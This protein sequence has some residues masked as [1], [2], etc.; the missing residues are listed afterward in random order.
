MLV[1]GK[2]RGVVST[3]DAP[4]NA[5]FPKHVKEKYSQCVMGYCRVGDIFGEKSSISDQLN[6]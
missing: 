2:V 5:Y 1:S 4:L 3:R 6:N